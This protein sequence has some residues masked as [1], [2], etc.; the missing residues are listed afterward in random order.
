VHEP[1]HGGTLR[2]LLEEDWRIKRT[3]NGKPWTGPLQ[4]ETKDGQLM[5]LPSDLALVKDP[6]T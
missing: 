6:G 5:M 2:L 4:Y 1:E 3:H